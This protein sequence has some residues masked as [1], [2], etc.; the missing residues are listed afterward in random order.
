MLQVNGLEKSYGSV[1]SVKGISFQVAS[2]EIVGLLGQN[3]AGK[4]TTLRMIAGFQAPTKGEIRFM[5]KEFQEIGAKG[6]SHLGYLPE[7]PPLYTDF[8]VKEHLRIVCDL[9]GIPKREWTEESLR[10]A[11]LLQVDDVFSR[12]IRHLSKGY[13]QRVGFAAAIIG[14][15]KLLILDEPA[16]GLDPKQLYEL[17]QLIRD[18]SKEMGIIL[19]SHML[20]EIT[21]LCHRIIIMKKGE[22]VANGTEAE[23]RASY[24][25][26]IQIELTLGGDIDSAVTV[27]QEKFPDIRWESKGEGAFFLH[28]PRDIRGELYETIARDC[29]KTTIYTLHL[30]TISMEEIFMEL[31][32]EGSP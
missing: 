10:V 3:G 6:R 13:R 30:N 17:R 8:T 18:L 31:S 23:I 24:Q 21:S 29:P 2:G 5:G 15:P 25:R 28:C 26:G 12:C 9:R 14:K 11:R 7:I 20:T 22:I 1:Q 32:Q 16:V 19:S 4:S 27:I